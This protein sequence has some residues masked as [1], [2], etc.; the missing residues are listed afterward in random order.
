MIKMVEPVKKL[1]WIEFTCPC[2]FRTSKWRDDKAGNESAENELADHI[3]ASP[4]CMKHL[5]AYDKEQVDKAN[6]SGSFIHP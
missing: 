4:K 6:L 3:K 5:R 1:H 2:G